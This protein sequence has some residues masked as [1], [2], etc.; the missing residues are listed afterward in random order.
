MRLCVYG[1]GAMGT[2]FGALLT[3]GGYSPDLVTRNRAHV[4]AMK[5]RGARLT[6]CTD[7]TVCVSALFPEEMTGKYDVI[8]LACKQRGNRETAEFL[9]P[10]LARDGALVTLQ[11]GLPER[12]LAEVLGKERIYGC[13]LSWGAELTEAGCVRVTSESGYHAALG[14][15]GAGSRLKE[16]E[17]I[18]SGAFTVTAGNLT[19]IRYAKLAVNASFS[20]LSA[21]SG[22]PFG[23]IAKKYKKYALALMR[24]TFSVA[25]AAGCKELPLNGHDLFRAFGGAFAGVLL[26]VA[27][28]KY[29]ETRSGMLQDLAAGRRCDVDFVAGAVAEEGKRYGVPTPRLSRAVE[30][31]HEIENGFAET[32]PE[33]IY[34]IDSE[35]L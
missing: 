10:F 13:A 32:A 29:A 23:T 33:T 25:R 3:E 27:M 21:I 6:G 4:G 31:V 1:A 20:T 5:E 11:N 18:L 35:V 14:A 16:I 15:Y 17:H 9:S 12:A 22:L 19:E 2:S 30:L 8:F 24:E 26:P 28:K 7:A 34:F